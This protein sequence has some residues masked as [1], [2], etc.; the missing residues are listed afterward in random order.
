MNP[1]ED[2]F[3][4]IMNQ[5][6]VGTLRN[7]EMQDILAWA[8]EMNDNPDLLQPLYDEMIQNGEIERDNS[9]SLSQ[10]SFSLDVNLEE[11]IQNNNVQWCQPIIILNDEISSAQ[12]TPEY[13]QQ[14]LQIS[15]MVDDNIEEINILDANIEEAM[16]TIL[17]LSVKHNVVIESLI[18]LRQLWSLK[19]QNAR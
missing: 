14:Q 1:N 16:T 15:N 17:K 2:L 18:V 8:E 12:I 10:L 4:N 19:Q 3:D 9:T 5:L 6:D 13:L 7:I 11:E